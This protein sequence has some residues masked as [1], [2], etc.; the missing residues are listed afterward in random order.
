M[1]LLLSAYW[2]VLGI[3]CVI[4]EFGKFCLKSKEYITISFSLILLIERLIFVKMSG[5]SKYLYWF[6]AMPIKIQDN[7]IWRLIFY[8]FQQIV[9]KW[10]NKL[11][12]KKTQQSNNK[13]N[14]LIFFPHYIQYQ[15]K[16]SKSQKHELNYKCIKVTVKE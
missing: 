16:M 13:K 4:E 14:S 15:F 2:Y 11:K 3:L 9:L 1:V 12:E 6:N 7:S 10:L 8:I 5:L